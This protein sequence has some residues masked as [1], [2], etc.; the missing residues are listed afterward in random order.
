MT[1]C[2]CYPNTMSYSQNIS[3]SSAGK[4]DLSLSSVILDKFKDVHFDETI[5]RIDYKSTL[6]LFCAKCNTALGDS[7]GICG[8]Y[9][10]L[11]SVICLKV[12][13]DVMVKGDQKPSV[14]GPLAT[15]IYTSLQCSGCFSVVGGVL[16]ATPPHLSA[17]RDFFLL[18]KDRINC[19]NMTDGMMV[20]G[21]TLNFE[22]KPIGEE[23]S[24]LKEELESQMKRLE[25]LKDLLCREN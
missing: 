2:N 14:E 9:A 16:Q 10:D 11:N 23:I 25:L 1:L 22:Q 24:E 12:T 3:C 6:V 18:Q 8:E 4:S 7:L 19:Y 5:I 15:C 13:E 17:L 21:S 20:A